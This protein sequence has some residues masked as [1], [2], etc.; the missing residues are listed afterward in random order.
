MKN[1][2]SSGPDGIPNEAIKAGEYVLVP[3]LTKLFNRILDKKSIPVEWAKSDII[4]LYKK[5]NPADIGNYRPIS[6]QP[7]IYKLFA[8]CVE[9]RLAAY[10]EK[11]QPVEQAGFRRNYS[12]IDHIHSLELVIEKYEEMNRPLYLAFIDYA[13]AFDSISHNSIWKALQE[14][15]VPTETIEL[16]QDIYKKSKSKVILEKQGSEIDICRGVRQGDPL[17]PRIF[18]AVLQSIMKNLKWKSKGIYINGKYLSNL[19]FADDIVLFAETA[20]QLEIMIR[21]IH[22]VSCKIGLQL[23]T[24]KTKIMTN[25]KTVPIVI[26]NAPIEYVHEYIYLGKQTSFKKSRHRDE[27]S[28]RVNIAWNKFWSL[29]E[30]LKSNLPVR[31]KKQVLDSCILPSLSY[32]SQTWIFNKFTRNKIVTTQRAMER[33]TLKLKLKHKRTNRDIRNTTKVI[34]ALHHC[35]MLKWKWA[36]H[37]SRMDGDRWTKRITTWNGPSGKRSRGRPMERW[38]DEI[39]KIAGNNWTEKAIDRDRWR[40]MEEAFTQ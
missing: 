16:I 9:D 3:L 36:G 21:E 39:S 6:L 26:A 38:L 12:T 1:G 8:S 13:K 23:N 7:N 25:S 2:K 30:V 24:N 10:T 32:A 4:L 15:D 31:L 35:K 29:K 37:V 28:R 20:P 34:D 19:R 40:K 33:S 14:C 11:E 17:S 5:G 18:I 27:L 22:N